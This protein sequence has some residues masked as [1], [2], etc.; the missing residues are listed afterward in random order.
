VT[1]CIQE[2]QR[3]LADVEAPLPPE[4]EEEEDQRWL[5][6]SSPAAIPDVEQPHLFLWP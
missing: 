5:A 3:W 2:G 1:N 4:E 6:A